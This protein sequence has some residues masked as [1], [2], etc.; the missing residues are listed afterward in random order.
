M[1]AKVEQP[2]K[3]TKADFDKVAEYV[4]EEYYKRKKS[5]ARKNLERMMKEIDRQLRLEPE[6]SHK[7]MPDG[8]PDRKKAWMPEMELPNQA[9]S[10][11]VLCADVSRIMFPDA[12]KWF[13]AVAYAPDDYLQRMKDNSDMITGMAVGLPSMITMENVNEY[14]EAF[15]GHVFKKFNHEKAW[16]LIIAESLKYSV[17]VGRVRMASKST[18]VHDATAS[19]NRSEKTPILVPMSLKNVYPDENEYQYMAHGAIVGGSVIVSMKRKFADVLMEVKK[20][21]GQK[22]SGWIA[23]AMDGMDVGKDGMVDFVEYEGDIVVP[24]S[25]EDH[26]QT[27]FLPN[28]VLTVICGKSGGNTMAGLARIQYKKTPQS[29]FIFVPY[30]QEHIDTPYCTSPLMKGYPIQQAASESLNSFMITA[31]LNAMPPVKIP[32]DDAFFKA[33]GGARI[34]PGAQWQ[35]NGDLEVVKIGDPAAM[36]NAY[37][38][39]N[40]QYAD[41]TGINA[42]RLGAQTVSHTTAFAKDQ[43]IERGTVR[44]VDF[45]R[46]V[47]K[48]PMLQ[49]MNMAYSMAKEE[50]GVNIEQ[51]YMPS[52]MAY[53]NVTS[54]FLP[55]IVCFTAQGSG[56]NAD[57]LAKQQQ[58]TSAL[59]TALQVNQ[60]AVQAGMAQP[61]NYD[62][63]TKQLL[64]QGGIT[65]VEAFTGVPTGDQAGQQIPVAGGGV[66]NPSATTVALQGLQQAIG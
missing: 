28:V 58:K 3:I 61:L 24:K 55:D 38:I 34:Y 22:D 39:L 48:Y 66:A 33:Q 35:T 63:I 64:K 18:F 52:V 36:I 45:A 53:V 57:S 37:T 62:A 60:L 10:L 13:T 26:T 51:M 32:R 21:S 31:M 6:R 12:G 29:S 2:E 42:P 15:T 25:G 27:L 54:E 8:S 23:D 43:E 65:D 50:L 41:V 49:W 11:E 59:M 5:K 19:Y 40:G 7:L 46:T 17:G 30:H 14:V 4:I 9:Q 1:E 56:G 20:G 47:L 44:T 16:D